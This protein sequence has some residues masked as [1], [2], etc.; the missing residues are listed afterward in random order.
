MGTPKSHLSLKQ[1]YRQGT[2]FLQ[3]LEFRQ[4]VTQCSIMVK[5]PI[6]RWWRTDECFLNR[7]LFTLSWTF[8]YPKTCN[9][10]FLSR[11]NQIAIACETNSIFDINLRKKTLRV[12]KLR[13]LGDFAKSFPLLKPVTVSKYFLKVSTCKCNHLSSRFFIGSWKRRGQL[14]H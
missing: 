7:A 10:Q 13:I 9:S 6:G 11:R 2:N 1:L 14:L 4:W 5:N 8:I 12:I 3:H